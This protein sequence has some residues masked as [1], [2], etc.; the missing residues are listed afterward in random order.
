MV[1]R[2]SYPP[3]VRGNEIVSRSAFVTSAVCHLVISDCTIAPEKASKS[4]RR[5]SKQKQPC[6][7]RPSGGTAKRNGGVPKT[8]VQKKVGGPRGLRQV[9]GPQPHPN[10]REDIRLLCHRAMVYK[11]IPARCGL[12]AG[13]DADNGRRAKTGEQQGCRFSGP[14][15][16]PYARSSARPN[17]RAQRCI[18]GTARA[19]CRF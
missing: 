14:G 17:E 9:F 5:N 16:T 1:R 12:E 2:Y 13:Q 19:W 10:L 3:P 15:T 7:R 11:F 4:R 8:K 6:P 18:G